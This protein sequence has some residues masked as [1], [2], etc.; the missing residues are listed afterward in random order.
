M[1]NINIIKYVVVFCQVPWK[2]RI[3]FTPMSLPGADCPV[4]QFPCPDS[5]IAYSVTPDTKL[6]LKLHFLFFYHNT[7]PI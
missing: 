3:S 4:P 7:E 5:A 1:L 2:F 6:L